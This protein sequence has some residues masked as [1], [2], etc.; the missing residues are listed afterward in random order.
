MEDKD[1]IKELFKEKLGGLE[2]PVRTDMWAN[3][4]S[5]IGVAGTGAATTGLSILSKTII[6]LSI[7]ASVG[8]GAYFIINN[9]T[10]EQKEENTE[11][12]VQQDVTTS[13]ETSDS[14]NQSNTVTSNKK[15]NKESIESEVPLIEDPEVIL[16]L[17]D[18]DHSIDLVDVKP[19]EVKKDEERMVVPPIKTIKSSI[20][21]KKEEKLEEKKTPLEELNSPIKTD[22]NYSLVISNVFT[23][24]GDGVHDVFEVKAEGLTDFNVV[25]LDQ[26]SKIIYQ[27]QDPM[28]QWNGELMD[29]SQAPVGAYLFYITARDRKG[30]LVTKSNRLY[31]QR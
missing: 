23:P 26:N 22:E 13:D 19:T 7:A 25:V 15:N 24:N 2:A 8:V 12:I 3:I 17:V 20:D 21:E 28:F 5:Q 10:S 18:I 6:G 27:S 16:D 14:I 4:S 31:I 9:S 29:G 30:E 1:F 11:K